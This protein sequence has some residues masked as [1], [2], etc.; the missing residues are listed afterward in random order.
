MRKIFLIIMA[1]LIMGLVVPV[2][3]HGRE[4]VG[5]RL[6]LR[7]GNQSYP[8][9]VPFHIMHGWGLILPGG[10]IG[11]FNFELEVDNVPI[12]ED[13]VDR[14]VDPSED[15]VA[16]YKFW[17]YNFPKGMTGTHSFT[18]HYYGPCNTLYG[19]EWCPPPYR[20]DVIE[21]W[22]ETVMVTFVP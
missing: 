21:D 2:S 8:A 14:F 17:V 19:P 12:K 5:D 9:N 15:K 13:F 6:N 3:A 4:Y 11:L 1:S 18:F 16:V 20:N 10:E 22:S 7:D